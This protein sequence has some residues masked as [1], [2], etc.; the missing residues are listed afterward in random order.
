MERAASSARCDAWC[1]C[2]PSRC[3]VRC[4][5]RYRLSR[6]WIAARCKSRPSRC[7]IADQ[8]AAWCRC[9]PS[10]RQIADQCAAWCGCR[11]SRR[12][13]ADQCAAWCR[14]RPSRCRIAAGVGAGRRA[15]GSLRKAA[16][17]KSISNYAPIFA[18]FVPFLRKK[19]GETCEVWH[20][21]TKSRRLSY[22]CAPPIV[23]QDGFVSPEQKT[24]FPGRLTA[25]RCRCYSVAGGRA[26]RPASRKQQRRPAQKARNPHE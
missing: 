9:R 15:A 25:C 3:P 14:C 10:R 17:E 20:I 26:S 24:G 18:L 11:P 8:C 19:V 12:Q 5:C 2:R 23:P 16:S 1:R 21:C 7:Q 4:R 6:C 13:I 22:A